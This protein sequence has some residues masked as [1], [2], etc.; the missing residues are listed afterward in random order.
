MNLYNS[1]NKINGLF[2]NKAINPSMYACDGA[3]ESEQ[4]FDESI[5]ERLKLR[6][7]KAGDN[8]DKTGDEQLDT[9]K[10]A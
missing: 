8:T 5:E 4:K 6:R 3:E 1:R 7:Q 9:T 2:E 10:H